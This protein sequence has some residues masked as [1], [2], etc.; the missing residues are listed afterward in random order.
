M[1]PV[2][3]AASTLPGRLAELAESAPGRESLRVI[4]PGEAD[5]T[6]TR[7]G[8][9]SAARAAAD[10]LAEAG[11]GPGDLVIL[12][13][14]DVAA[15]AMCFFGAS[16]TGAIP[17]IMPFQTE[18][19]HPDRYRAA[20]SALIDLSGPRAVITESTLRDD[21]AALLPNDGPRL[22][23]LDRA[24]LL[25]AAHPPT[26]NPAIDPESI[27]LLQ[28]SS[29]TTG[30]Q[31]GVALS[32]RAIFEQIERYGAALGFSEDDVIVS[33]LPL[34]HDMG[35]IA[36]FLMPI[37][38]G[39][40]LVLMNPLDWVRAPHMLLRAISDHGGTLCWLP[41]FAY[42]FCAQKIRDDDLADVDLSSMRAFINCSEPIYAQSHDQFLQRFAPCGVERS[43]LHTSY[44]MAEAVF[45]V[46][47]SDLG[48]PVSVDVVDRAALY[49]DGAASPP[50]AGKAAHRVVSSGRPIPGMAVRVLD[51]DRAPLPDR[52]V[53]EIAIRSTHML[54]G[55]YRR[56]D[57]TER[58]FHDGWYLTGDMGYLSGGEVYVLGRKKDLIIVGGR[59]IYPRDLETLVNA[60]AGVHP[61]RVV[62]FGV[63]NPARGTE[64]VAVIAELADEV[65]PNGSGTDEDRRRIAADIRRAVAAGTDIMVR[66]V[67]LVPRGW[68][69]KTSSGKVARAANRDRFL[70][71]HP[72]ID[73]GH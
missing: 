4:A 5:L 69:V 58:A 63:P 59:N 35:L 67:E 55:Y 37:L 39:A 33:W 19:L 62:A 12:I 31:K 71:A 18:K 60:V 23:A 25:D 2:R 20:M 54:S 26:I 43:M 47:Q 14:R 56:P 45:A 6:L 22:I 66:H 8:F 3:Q 30:L 53:G 50:V 40:R 29:G 64:D 13:Q 65:S 9:F 49:T 73:V 17:S 34:Y 42:N 32:H 11:V 51:A 16:L 57:E 28:H 68:L 38:G 52:H 61:G 72:E 27:A 24:D 36:G 48:A 21:V 70:A 44:A 7:A 10:R 1:T 41:N 15:L 46:S